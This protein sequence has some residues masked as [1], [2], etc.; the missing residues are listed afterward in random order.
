M[1]SEATTFSPLRSRFQGG[2]CGLA[3][4]ALFGASTPVLKLL[5]PETGAVML[6][7]LLYVGAAG[8]VWLYERGMRVMGHHRH[9]APLRRADLLPALGVVVCG[10]VVGPILMLIGLERVSGVVG[11]LLL[12]L[13][14][15]FTMIQAIVIFHEHLSPREAVAAAVIVAGAVLLGY[16]PDEVRVDAWGVAAL[17]GA[18]LAWAI[19]NNLSQHLSLRDPLAIVKL[20]GLGAGACALGVGWFT[21]QRIPEPATMTAALALG[22]VSYGASLVLDIRALRLLGAEREAA[23]F[24]TAPFIGAFLSMP[25]L[26]EHPSTVDVTSAGL[27][28]LGVGMLLSAHHEHVHAHEEIEHEHLHEHDEHHRHHRDES[29]LAAHSHPHVHERFSHDHTHV[30]DVHHRHAHS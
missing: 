5:V 21:G 13:E 4:A 20:K 15:A 3:A 1:G 18:C 19:D 23:F 24:A 12:N 17:A 28:A 11:S 22:A 16:R 27:L 30:S 2:L 29:A 9:E 10:G 7:G 26:G 14:A 25:V 6:A 8:G